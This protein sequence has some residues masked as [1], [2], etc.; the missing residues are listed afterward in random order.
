M[1]LSRF[2]LPTFFLLFSL[3]MAAQQAAPPWIPITKQDP[4]PVTTP[5]PQDKQAVSILNQVLAVA[6]GAQAINAIT[7]YRASGKITYHG[8]SEVVADTTVTARGTETFRMDAYLAKGTR[9]VAM[10]DGRTSRRA[11]DGS[12]AEPPTAGRAVPSSDAFPYQTPLFPGSMILPYSELVPILDNSIF[13][14]SY[15]GIVQVDGHSAHQI[16]V[17]RVLPGILPSKDPT[18]EFHTRDFFID[19]ST[20]QVLMTQDVVPK[21]TVHRV[22]Y[23]DYKVTNNV[24]VPFSVSE[25]MGGQKTWTISLSQVAFNSGLQDSDFAL[26]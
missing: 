5:A 12:I 10:H 23:S 9:S 13:G 14:I 20:F 6:G 11:E 25:E 17:Q 22:R 7:D 8:D 3:P 16:Q 15:K 2:A 4:P 18:T 1:P 19:T 26:R 21:H 24:L